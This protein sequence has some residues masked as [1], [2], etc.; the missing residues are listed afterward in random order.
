MKQEEDR[1]G[2]MWRQ[3]AYT[4]GVW[5]IVIAPDAG[6]SLSYIHLIMNLLHYSFHYSWQNS[7]WLQL[8][9]HC[10]T[11]YSMWILEEQMML[12]NTCRL[13]TSRIH[14][15]VKILNDLGNCGII[16]HSVVVCSVKSF[17]S[18]DSNYNPSQSQITY[19]H[20]QQKWYWSFLADMVQVLIPIQMERSIFMVHQLLHFVSCGNF[21]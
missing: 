2:H 17:S 5:D 1:W 13:I 16:S 20:L 9:E 6:N 21:L 19:K 11:I 15:L 10:T 8:A 3:K 14:L 7:I 12:K 4:K 18:D